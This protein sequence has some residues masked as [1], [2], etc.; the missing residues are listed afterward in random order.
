MADPAPTVVTPYL[1]LTEAAQYVRLAP[2]TLYNH[3]REIVAVRSRPL[4]FRREDLDA[5]LAAPRRSRKGVRR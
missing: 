4:L 2:Q 1:T 3:R 5:W